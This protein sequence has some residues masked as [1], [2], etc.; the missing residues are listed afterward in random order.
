M[1]MY[2]LSDAKAQ[3][4]LKAAAKRGVKVR[5]LLDSDTAGGGNSTMN[6]AAYSD[7]TTNGVDVR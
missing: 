1:T 7:L 3:N 5:V 6:Q 2:Q 4:T